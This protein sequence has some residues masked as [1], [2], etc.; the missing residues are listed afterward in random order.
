MIPDLPPA[1][2]DRVICSVVAAV[3]WQVPANLVIAVAEVEGG[4]PGLWVRNANGTHDVG[5]MQLN[6]AYLAELRRFGITAAD[7]A[8]HGCYPYE[9]A[10]WRL[11]GHLVR[12]RGDLWTRAANYHSRT[13]RHNAVYRRKLIAAAG[14]WARWL[15]ERFN[16]REV[17]PRGSIDEENR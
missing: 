3:R 13:P 2:E 17:L 12:D 10:T 4:R 1:L 14:R 15:A 11:K 16:V 6:T 7:V 8:A 9:L 5:P